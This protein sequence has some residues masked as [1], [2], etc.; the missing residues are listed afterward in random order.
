MK[1]MRQITKETLKFDLNKIQDFKTIRNVKGI[2]V[3]QLSNIEEL[4]AKETVSNYTIL[5]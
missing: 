3:F 1:E 4:Y 2:K 5:I